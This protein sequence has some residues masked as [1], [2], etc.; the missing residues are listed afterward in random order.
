MTVDRL[1]SV[2]YETYDPKCP[3]C[4]NALGTLRHRVLECPRVE[5]TRQRHRAALKLIE[6]AADS[7][8]W[9]VVSRHFQS[10]G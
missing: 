5:Q 2:G 6:D 4:E 10:P 8:P 3:L 1:I 7:D 9:L